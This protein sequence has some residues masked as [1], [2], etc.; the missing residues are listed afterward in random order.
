M[1]RIIYFDTHTG[2]RKF[3]SDNYNIIAEEHM[4]L[5][6]HGCKIICIVD[7]NANVV[8]NKCIDFKAH[9]HEV[10]CLIN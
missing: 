9:V 10:D 5:K 2:Y 8:L 1:Y 7:Y 3:D 6:K 4:I